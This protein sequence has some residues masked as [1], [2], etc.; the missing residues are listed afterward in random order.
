MAKYTFGKVHFWKKCGKTQY[1]YFLCIFI[2]ILKVFLPHFVAT[3]FATFFATLFT[4]V[5][6][7]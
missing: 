2:Y 3:L 4:K 5:C 6:F 1:L 7:K